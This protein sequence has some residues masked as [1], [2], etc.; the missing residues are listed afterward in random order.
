MADTLKPRDAKD[1]EGA[2]QWALAEGKAI[3]LNNPG[4]ET[5]VTDY[6]KSHQ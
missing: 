5:F 4:L 2:V 1:V 3:G 6:I